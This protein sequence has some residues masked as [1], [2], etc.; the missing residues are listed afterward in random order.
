MIEIHSHILPGIDDGALSKEEALE[1][2]RQAANQGITDIIATPHHGDGVYDNP[3]PFVREQVDALNGWFRRNGLSVKV[4]AGQEIRVSAHL[5]DD[6]EADQLLT[7]AGSRYM[8][9]ELPSSHVPPN[10]GEWIHELRVHGL[11]PVIAHPE[12]NKAAIASPA[13]IAS[14]VEQGALC[15]LTSH[16]LLGH[17]GRKL[18][19]ESLHLCRRNLIHFVASDAHNLE[20]RDFA[21]Q[22]AFRIIASEIGQETVDRYAANGVKLLQDDE[23]DIELPVQAR[24]RRLFW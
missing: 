6:W 2:A 9:V 5:I 20:R 4:H 18:Q 12:R 8:L 11:V 15:Q 19:K 24:R 21:L 13:L 10:F 22:A 16:S 7:L 1:M 23:I 3:K 17:F 14:W